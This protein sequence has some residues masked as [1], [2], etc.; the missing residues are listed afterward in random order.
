MN[1]YRDQLERIMKYVEA[2]NY[3]DEA[4]GSLDINL[5]ARRLIE[6]AEFREIYFRFHP[7]KEESDLIEAAHSRIRV[8]RVIAS[9]KRDR[10][11][12]REEL[13]MPCITA[14]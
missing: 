10:R 6:L 8:N 9:L 5:A 2:T 1:A 14:A 7:E 4:F 11:L 12:T 3:I 13:N